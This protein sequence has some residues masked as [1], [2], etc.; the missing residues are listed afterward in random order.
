MAASIRNTYTKDTCIGNTCVMSIWI[1]CFEVGDTCTRGI[2]ARGAF[3]G[4]VEPRTLVGS[5]VI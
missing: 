1:R 5:R 4:G 3:V 2:Y